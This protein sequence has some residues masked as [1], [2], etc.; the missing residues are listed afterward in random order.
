M[1]GGSPCQDK[2][3]AFGK[4]AG[5]AL[6]VPKSYVCALQRHVELN[7]APLPLLPDS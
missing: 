4:S 5:E 7:P 3:S 6:C 1:E 2:D